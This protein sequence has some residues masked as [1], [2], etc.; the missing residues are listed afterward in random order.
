[1]DLDQNGETSFLEVQAYFAANNYLICRPVRSKII[2]RQRLA[3]NNRKAMIANSY[4]AL[5]NTF[6]SHRDFN[7]PQ[8]LNA[9]DL[10]LIFQK[11]TNKQSWNQPTYKIFKDL[12]TSQYTIR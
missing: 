8:K 7:D 10:L 12:C 3:L 1:M 5:F 9:P 4:E 6:N 11:M 2:D